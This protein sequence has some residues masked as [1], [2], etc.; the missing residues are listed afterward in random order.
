MV[1]ALSSFSVRHPGGVECSEM[2]LPGVRHGRRLGG[3]QREVVGASHA[4]AV[5]VGNV[6]HLK[7]MKKILLDP[8][9]SVSFFL[10]SSGERLKG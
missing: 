8:L 1:V 10:F 5:S 2:R 9:Y 3:R 7:N 4:E 6:V